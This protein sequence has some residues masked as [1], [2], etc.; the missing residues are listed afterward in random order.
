MHATINSS[1]REITSFFDQHFQ[2]EELSPSYIE[3]LI[4][5][6]DH[7]ALPQQQPAELM[8]LAPSTITRF[9]KK[10]EKRGLVKKKKDKGKVKVLLSDEG[11]KSAKRYRKSYNSAVKSLSDILGDKFVKTTEQLLEHGITLM[12]NAEE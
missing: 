6:L 9:V 2:A 3:L 7:D 10:L 11:A 5:L 4:T 1:S 12:K 8:T